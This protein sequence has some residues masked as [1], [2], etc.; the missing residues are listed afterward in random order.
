MITKKTRSRPHNRMKNSNNSMTHDML[1]S[2]D[3]QRNDHN[4]NRF[5]QGQRNFQ[6]LFDKYTNMAR[7]ALSAGDRVAAEFHY[8]Y[9]DHYL[10]LMNERQQQRLHPHHDKPARQETLQ[11]REQPDQGAILHPS[12]CDTTLP[13]EEVEI[14]EENS[15]KSSYQE[16]PFSA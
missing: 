11:S 14:T 3:G 10:R 9:A 5:S 1:P 15:I 12:S 4:K 13:P 6:Q 2:F 7:E 8:Q 16:Q